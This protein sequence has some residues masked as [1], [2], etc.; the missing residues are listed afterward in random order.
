[1]KKIVLLAIT[2]ILAVCLLSGCAGSSSSSSG[3]NKNNNGNDALQQA[4]EWMKNNTYTDR[5]GTL[6]WK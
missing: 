3:W 5:N 1:M 4:Q 6:R 2:L